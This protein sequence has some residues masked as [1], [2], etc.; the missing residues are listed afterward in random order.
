[1]TSFAQTAPD[2][3]GLKRST[4]LE[5]EETGDREFYAE[6][7]LSKRGERLEKPREGERDSTMKKKEYKA[8]FSLPA[9]RAVIVVDLLPVLTFFCWR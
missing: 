9:R 7:G 5:M 6:K 2:D 4:K 8:Y 3:D 1:M